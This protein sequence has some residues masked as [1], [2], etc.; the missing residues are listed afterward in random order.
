V[1]EVEPASLVLVDKVVVLG[2]VLQE[3]MRG[4]IKETAAALV[5][6]E[7]VE[8]AALVVLLILHPT[9]L[10]LDMQVVMAIVVVDLLRAVEILD[11]EDLVEVILVLMVVLV[12]VVVVAIVAVRELLL[13]ETQDLVTQVNPEILVIMGLMAIQVLL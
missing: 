10:V 2:V 11:H 13:M 8:A 4:E 6:E 9:L 12:V 1:V 5:A 7:E 3:I